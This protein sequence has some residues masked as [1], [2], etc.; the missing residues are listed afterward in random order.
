M[1][2]SNKKAYYNYFVVEDFNAGLVLVGSE[3]KSI[4][5][6]DMNFGDSYIF[7]KDG[8]LFIKNM[9]IAQYKN[10]TYQ[11]HDEMRDKKILLNKKEIAKISKAVG[12]KGVS[13][14]PLEILTM[15]NKIKLKIGICRGKKEYNKREDIKKKDI[16]REFQR[17]F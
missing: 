3:V 12:D 1:K 6:N 15:N 7:F 5:N 8:E 4:L 16:E 2:I 11:N 14:M 9:R 13:I 17:K 10:A